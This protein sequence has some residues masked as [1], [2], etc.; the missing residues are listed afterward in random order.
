MTLIKPHAN[1][2]KK[3]I[4]NSRSNAIVMAFT[5]GAVFLC[6]IIKCEV[7]QGCRNNADKTVSAGFGLSG[8]RSRQYLSVKLAK[9]DAYRTGT[10]APAAENHGVAVFQEASMFIP[11]DGQR[12]GAAFAQFHQGTCLRRRR[13]GL[14]AAAEQ[15]TRAQIAAVDRMVRHQL[16]NAPIGVTENWSRRAAAAP[17]RARAFS[18]SAAALAAVC[19]WHPLPGSPQS[20]NMATVGGPT[21]GD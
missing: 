9:S 7:F 4:N 12:L 20:P 21:P 6:A 1:I 5:G 3:Q 8:N 16:R 2:K 19:R 15:I 14:R 11:A 10:F 13:T 18:P 17:R